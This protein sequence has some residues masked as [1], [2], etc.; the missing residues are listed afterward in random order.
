MLGYVKVITAF[1]ATLGAVGG[2]IALILM[3]LFFAAADTPTSCGTRTGP[4]SAVL[5]T[6]RQLESGGNYRA[7]A[8]GSSASGAYQ[9]ID[10]TWNNYGGYT[11]AAD[12]P[13][14]TQDAK[15]TEQVNHI[16]EANNQDITAI[17]IVWYIGHLPPAGSPEWDTIPAAYAGNTITPRQYQQRWIALYN[18][19][20]DPTTDPTTPPNA[21]SATP[22]APGQT[23]TVYDGTWALPGPDQTLARTT[24]QFDSPHH[25]YPAWDWI[26]PTG[27]PIYAI[28][29]GTVIG[30]N[31]NTINTYN[32][33]THDAC[34][35]GLTILDDQG[36][37]WTYCHGSAHH[38]NQGS[39]V[40]AGQQILDSGNTGNSSGPHTHIQIRAAGTNR[41]PQP[42]I[43]S[44]YHS[45]TGIDPNT[46]PTS[47]CTY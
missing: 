43:T 27:T 39:T 40:T 30:Y 14:E 3:P 25:D 45:H 24:D 9:F 4:T 19:Q 16:L 12:A 13:P 32:D 37:Q 7:Q 18:Q 42:L 22:C 20:L 28:H 21:S 31:T 41:C 10:T 46:L 29:A 47:G 36:T 6:I 11:H 8:P 5:A 33:N 1:L 44:L 23:G 34:G 2:L 38:V 26:I 35:I 17:P 15:A